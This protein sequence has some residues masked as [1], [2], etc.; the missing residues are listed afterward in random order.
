MVDRDQYGA[1]F[2]D[3]LLCQVSGQHF[4]GFSDGGCGEVGVENLQ[5]LGS[6]GLFLQEFDVVINY[7]VI[8][9]VAILESPHGFIGKFLARFILSPLDFLG[10]FV[11]SFRIEPNVLDPLIILKP[12]QR[13]I[14]SLPMILQTPKLSDVLLVAIHILQPNGL[15]F[16]HRDASFHLIHIFDFYLPL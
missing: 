11:I 13:I 10:G 16:L 3:V 14:L 4:L 8:Q 12:N 2:Q 15:Q 9:P 1:F 5:V 6:F 7:L